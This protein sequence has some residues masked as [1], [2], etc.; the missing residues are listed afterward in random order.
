MTPRPAPPAAAPA[1]D[2]A[3]LVAARRVLVTGLAGAS[4]DAARA[5]CDLAATLGAAVDFGAADVDRP[6][7]PTIARAGAV[8]ADPAEMHDR[9][10]LV[11]LW[12]C[13]PAATHPALAALVPARAAVVRMPPG[14][15]TSIDAARLLHHLVCVGPEPEA[16]APWIRACRAAREAIERA[17]CVAVVTA[18]NAD[19]VGL[20]PWAVTHLVRA[21]AHRKPAFEISLDGSDL[22][23]AEAVCTWRHGASGAIARADRDGG[24]FLPGEASARRLLERREV[25]CVLAV[26]RLATA[27]EDAIARCGDDLEV[28]RVAAEPAALRS[29]LAALDR[30]PPGA[31]P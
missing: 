19:P 7:G 1:S 24:R 18:T 2:A 23:A 11:I 9:A 22:A 26:G 31:A 28:L 30:R 21:I 20:E 15:A 13:D 25:D 8:T 27:V 29:L 14:G 5:A 3:R 12:G 10:D 6:A 4:V 17:S 16:D